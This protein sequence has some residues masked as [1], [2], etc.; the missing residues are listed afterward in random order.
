LAGGYLPGLR[1]R[2]GRRIHVWAGVALVL[3]VATH[4]AGLWITSAPDVIDALLLRSPTPFS[5][6]GV[7]AMWAV[8]AAASLAA[9]RRPLRITPPL[10]RV[11]HS[12][13]VLVVAAGSIVHAL[14]VEG[15]MG[16]ASKAVLCALVIAALLK[17]LFDLRVWTVLK[18]RRD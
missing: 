4:V 15:I 8:F 3:A 6:W 14:L 10:W 2:A 17:T 12:V 7:M 13:L 9:L 1:L 11:G 16:T 18:L 5:L